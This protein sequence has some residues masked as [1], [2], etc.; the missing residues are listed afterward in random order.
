MLI[1]GGH[2]IGELIEDRTIGAFVA[3]TAIGQIGQG[4]PHTAELLHLAVDFG[5][6]LD[7][8]DI[9]PFVLR[10]RGGLALDALVVLSGKT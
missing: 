6:A 7:S 5:N 2:I 10:R 3:V 8:I 1:L 9:N 4:R